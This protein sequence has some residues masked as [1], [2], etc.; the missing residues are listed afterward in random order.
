MD[1]DS[2]MV[3][4]SLS[5]PPTCPVVSGLTERRKTKRERRRLADITE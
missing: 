3:P 4:P 5:C 1:P 2:S